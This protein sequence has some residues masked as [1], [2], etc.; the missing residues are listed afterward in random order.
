MRWILPLIVFVLSGV[1]G[2]LFV[3]TS[4]PS[5]IMGKAHQTFEAQG[6]PENVFGFL[7]QIGH[8]L[9]L[10]CGE[11]SHGSVINAPSV[12]GVHGDSEIF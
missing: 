7:S 2:H 11:N 10:D 12:A 8:R 5:F 6:I 9:F 4:L 1:I 3:L